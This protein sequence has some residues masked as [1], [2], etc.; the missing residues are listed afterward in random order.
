M[1]KQLEPYFIALGKIALKDDHR[2]RRRQIGY[3]YN[4][5]MTA[6][7]QYRSL[8]VTLIAALHPLIEQPPQIVAYARALR[9]R[10]IVQL[11][12]PPVTVSV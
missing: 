1:V 9:R 5:A 3:S 2:A 4:V 8:R 10:R 7:V 11:P 6:M 12:F